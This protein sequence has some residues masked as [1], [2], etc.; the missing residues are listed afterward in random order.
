[1]K[2][3]IVTFRLKGM[4]TTE[5]SIDIEFDVEKFQVKDRAREFRQE[6]Q[7]NAQY[8]TNDPDHIIVTS[9]VGL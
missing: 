5:Y 8:I 2:A 9:S 3:Y 7:R 4:G 1:M 6:V